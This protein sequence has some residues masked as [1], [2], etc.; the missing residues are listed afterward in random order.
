MNH[1][2]NQSGFTLIELLMV[3]LLL[4]M[5]A[6]ATF[7]STRSTMAV[8]RGVDSRTELLQSGR[9][10]ME[11]FSRDLRA[12]FFV[13]ANDLGWNPKQPKSEEERLAEG[14]TDPARIPIEGEE[15]YIPP[16]PP[17]PVPVTIFQGTANELLFS[18]RSHQRMNADVP[19]NNEHFVRYRVEGNQLIRE[20]SFRA[21]NK[22]DVTDDRQFRSF[23]L[24]ENLSSIEF[25]FWNQ[26]AER[27]DDRW[28]TN[29]SDNLDELPDAVKVK[30]KYT[31][32]KMEEG[33]GATKEVE[34]ESA[35]RLTQKFY[36]EK[37]IKY[38]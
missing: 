28:D 11:L 12:S 36:K 32:E 30:L 3:S 38:P 17:K 27:W 35:I 1:R 15:G 2:S 21:I 14:E 34:Y 18:T 19:E 26:K 6:Y 9:S 10:V 8:K 13:D 20:E 7:M 16:P 31:P 23:V 24:L 4:F 5:L 29:S 37:A 22:D 25:S 33:E